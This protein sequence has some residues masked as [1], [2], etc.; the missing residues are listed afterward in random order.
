M[1]KT[2]QETKRVSGI[3]LEFGHYTPSKAER[4]RSIGR[5]TREVVRPPFRKGMGAPVIQS[6]Q[7]FARL[8]PLLNTSLFPVEQT[9]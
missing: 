5:R 4:E 3:Q 1:P 7:A 8:V 2:I 9:D 6:I